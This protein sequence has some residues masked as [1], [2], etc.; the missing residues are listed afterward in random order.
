MEEPMHGVS[1]GSTPSDDR[2][3]KHFD[4]YVMSGAS[5]TQARISLDAYREA[6]KNVPPKPF[7]GRIFG[8]GNV[9][10]PLSEK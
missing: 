9:L 8:N 6:L 5:R 2:E 4:R 7:F 1:G 10:R 3:S